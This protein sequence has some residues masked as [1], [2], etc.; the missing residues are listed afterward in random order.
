M[1][2]DA[3]TYSK[4]R[5]TSNLSCC[6]VPV[7]VAILIQLKCLQN[8]SASTALG[9]HQPSP[10]LSLKCTTSLPRDIRALRYPSRSSIGRGSS[11]LVAARTGLFRATFGGVRA[12]GR[13]G[14]KVNGR[15][16]E[17]RYMKWLGVT[18]REGQMHQILLQILRSKRAR[19][20]HMP[21][22]LP[23]SK[24][25]LH[26]LPGPMMA[27]PQLPDTSDMGRFQWP[28]LLCLIR[29]RTPILRQARLRR[30]D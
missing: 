29:S 17:T 21:Q 5:C 16:R 9:L 30:E 26:Q 13:G 12:V 28:K 23:P 20:L 4:L 6:E 22:I 27:Q 19:P 10:W 24:A 11:S 15:S 25:P 1:C 8:C 14:N 7:D 3:I 18:C 2:W